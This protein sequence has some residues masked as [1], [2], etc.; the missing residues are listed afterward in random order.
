MKTNKLRELLNEGMPTVGTR[1]WDTWPTV[2]E[3]AATSGNLDYVEFV[4][5]YVPFNELALENLVRACE[6]G[7][8]GSI[9][10]IDFQNRFYTAQ[11]AL[12][13]GFQGVL[14]AD[15]KT[16]K[17]VEE[18]IW[19]I[20]P[21]SPKD[22]G[23]FGYPNGRW[24]GFQPRNP[25]MEY[26]AMVRSAVKAFMIEKKEAMDNLEEI[27]SVKGVDMVQFGPS[28]YS[29]SMGWDS[30]DHKNE[31]R[32]MEERMIRIA[33][34]HGVEPRCEIDTPEQAEYYRKLG[35]RHFCAGDEFR[36]LMAYWQEVCG[37]VRNL[38]DSLKK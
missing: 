33:L 24:I 1:I 6:L 20:R 16:A 36:I 15:H 32:D 4:A 35:V 17:E 34:E 30:K 21:D 2:V 29:M 38:A 25:Q 7:N 22:K 28:D 13:V 11:R 9:I 5:E 23:R 18:T 26:A 14:F 8:L 37:Q 3:A 19:A 10:K 12:A 31:L 27:C